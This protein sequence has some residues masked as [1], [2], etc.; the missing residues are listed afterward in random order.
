MLNQL[1]KFSNDVSIS[2]DII[3]VFDKL[4]QIPE[5]ESQLVNNV[6]P[7][8]AQILT[9]NSTTSA[10]HFIE[11]LL[12]LSNTIIVHAQK[13]DILSIM[14]TLYPSLMSLAFNNDDP[15]WLQKVNDC[16]RSLVHIGEE[17]ISQHRF[18]SG[19]HQV[20]SFHMMLEY[21]N[22]L[23]QPNFDDTAAFGVGELITELFAKVGSA[24][25]NEIVSKILTACISKLAS[26]DLLSF[27]Q[28]I[29]FIFA[30]LF[31]DQNI[32]QMLSLLES[33]PT[34]TNQKTNT[35]FAN[36]L[37]CLFTKWSKNQ[38]FFF[39]TYKLKVT[40]TA[41]AKLLKSGDERLASVS[42]SI[43]VVDQTAGYNTRSK[44]KIKERQ[45][46]F[47]LHAFIILVDAYIR[48]KETE[49]DKKKERN[50][51]GLMYGNDDDFEDEDESPFVAEDEYLD[52]L[53]NH[54]Q[55]YFSDDEDAIVDTLSSRDPLNNIDLLQVLPEAMK[56][57]CSANQQVLPHL[58]KLLT[59]Q[60]KKAL[61]EM[62]SK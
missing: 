15:A 54:G 34:L 3:H 52:Q 33:I 58:E 6:V 35:V 22:K 9:S 2:N 53:A 29:V 30:K 55:E 61:Q 50:L 28:S 21:I 12:E 32:V 43:E 13:A 19:Q 42:V 37:A 18:T 56:E 16:L 10:P 26:S 17:I 62:L 46:P 1:D 7:K 27:I 59:P 5:T 20:S 40:S 51:M 48:A 45:V 36:G 25:N 38:Q 57:I 39:D 11:N 23:L 8:I 4:A 60:Q 47:V 41:I 49:A 24:L 44:K 14:N 31:H